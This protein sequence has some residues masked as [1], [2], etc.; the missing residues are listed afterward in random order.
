MYNG[1]MSDKIVASPAAVH[2]VKQMISDSGIRITFEFSEDNVLLMAKMAE[3]KR[4][5]L[6]LKL[7]I[8]EADKE[9]EWSDYE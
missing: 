6:L 8:E 4:M 2:E 1:G 5:G 9:E 7:T 3:A